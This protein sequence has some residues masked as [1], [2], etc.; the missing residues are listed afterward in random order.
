MS[1]NSPLIIIGMNVFGWSDSAV[2]FV[3]D[4]F[5]TL[6]YQRSL[7]ISSLNKAPYFT[8]YVFFAIATDD[9]LMIK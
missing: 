4:L 6:I 2:H 8:L 1:E 9:Q 7:V 5:E 3:F